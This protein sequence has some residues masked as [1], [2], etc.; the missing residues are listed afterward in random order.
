MGLMRPRHRIIAEHSG[1]IHINFHWVTTRTAQ[2]VARTVIH[3]TSHK[4]VG[5]RDHAYKP[6]KGN[7]AALTPQ[8]AR[9]NA[10]SIAC[11]AYY[12]W[13]NGGAYALD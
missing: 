12:T 4:F 11:F 3:E 1:R 6:D 13:K 9:A 10:D 8:L 2:R 7:Y 5:T